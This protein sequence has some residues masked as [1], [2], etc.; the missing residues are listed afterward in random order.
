[1][2]TVLSHSFKM[3]RAEDDWQQII[4]MQY[5]LL[6]PSDLC[7]STTPIS[8]AYPINFCTF[9]PQSPTCLSPFPRVLII[10]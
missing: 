10:P 1:M 6:N 3:H 9:V 2:A 4:K 8:Y 5:L 7:S